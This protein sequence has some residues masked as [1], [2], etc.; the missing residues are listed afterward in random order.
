VFPDI[1]TQAACV[2][3]NFEMI[4]SF[5]TTKTV[6]NFKFKEWFHNPGN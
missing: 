6:A 1:N 4:I 2:Y 3:H 5:P